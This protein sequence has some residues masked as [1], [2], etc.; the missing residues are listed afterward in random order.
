MT[1]APPYARVRQ[2]ADHAVT[3]TM[4]PPES[5]VRQHESIAVKHDN[6]QHMLDIL[7][8]VYSAAMSRADLAGAVGLEPTSGTFPTYLPF[9]PASQRARPGNQQ[10][11]DRLGDPV[12]KSWNHRMTP[13]ATVGPDQLLREE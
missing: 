11:P 10:R 3:M 6:A 1:V 4:S 5:I 12:P 13:G 8:E 9:E 2:R 7:I